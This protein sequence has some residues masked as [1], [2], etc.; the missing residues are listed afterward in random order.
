LVALGL[1]GRFG[2]RTFLLQT[3][4]NR[5]TGKVASTG[6]WD[7]YKQAKDGEIILLGHQQ[8]LDRAQEREPSIDIHIDEVRVVLLFRALTDHP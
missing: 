5:L 8:F 4:S 2:G 6:S 7:A 3:G 1:R